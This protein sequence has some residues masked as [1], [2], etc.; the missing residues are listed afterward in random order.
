MSNNPV[1]ETVGKTLRSRFGSVSIMALS[2]GILCLGALNVGFDNQDEE[3]GPNHAQSVERIDALYNDLSAQKQQLE[4]ATQQLSFANTQDQVELSNL[5]D[6][7]GTLNQALT[8]NT[9]DFLT[10][11]Y[12]DGNLSEDEAYDYFSDLSQVVD[13]TSAENIL[14]DFDEAHAS[15]AF[16]HLREARETAIKTGM[17]GNR[18][19]DVMNDYMT[20]KGESQDFLETM[21]AILIG[22][23]IGMCGLDRGLRNIGN[24]RKFRD[25]ENGRSTTPFKKPKPKH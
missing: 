19:M 9:S 18:Q 8:D 21:I 16:T 23:A 13:E 11:L 4:E 6:Q 20:E 24:S 12:T 17:T 7:I 2:S 3:T 5:Q 10:Q 15:Y 22:L 14:P 25:W 1:R